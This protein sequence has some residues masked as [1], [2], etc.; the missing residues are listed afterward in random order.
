M[1]DAIAFG[2]CQQ[3][4]KHCFSTW[5]KGRGGEGEHGE[6]ALKATQVA[7]SAEAVCSLCRDNVGLDVKGAD[8]CFYMSDDVPQLPHVVLIYVFGQC[9]VIVTS[10]H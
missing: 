5:G 4:V 2:E 10:V 3:L 1:C 7:S 6:H 9:E 8:A